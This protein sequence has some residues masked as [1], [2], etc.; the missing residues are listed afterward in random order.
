MR[1]SR[2]SGLL[3]I[4]STQRG[5]SVWDLLSIYLHGTEAMLHEF[6]LPPLVIYAK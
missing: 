5:T 3:I 6:D 1:G 4:V 2:E